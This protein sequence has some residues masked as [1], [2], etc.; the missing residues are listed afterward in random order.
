VTTTTGSG[1][2]LRTASDGASA[3]SGL[4]DQRAG[5]TPTPTATLRK[6]AAKVNLLSG[7]REQPPTKADAPAKKHAKH[8][9]KDT[10]GK[11][12]AKGHDRTTSAAHAKD[13]T[14]T[15][16]A[17]KPKK[18][19]PGSDKPSKAQAP[20]PGGQS[21]D[22][23]SSG[24]GGSGSSGNGNGNGPGKKSDPGPVE[25]IIGIVGGLLP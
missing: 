24:N 2:L 8:D 15:R 13:A 16:K 19:D 12:K 18:S 3:G 22:P 23:G 14:D 10:K 4:V 1:S 11:H 21:D 20:G 9:A 5:S 6:T 7:T 25:R 17:D